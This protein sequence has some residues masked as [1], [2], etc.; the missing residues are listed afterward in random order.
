MRKSLHETGEIE[1]YLQQEMPAPEKALFEAKM[2]IVS[3][4][5]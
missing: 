4:H 1:R 5:R 2:I 3:C